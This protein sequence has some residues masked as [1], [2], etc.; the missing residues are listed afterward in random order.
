MAWPPSIADFCVLG[1]GS[2]SLAPEERQLN[3]VSPAGSLFELRGHGFVGGELVRLVPASAGSV[4][5]SGASYSTRYTV[6][7]TTDPDFFALV[8][9]AIADAGSGVLTLLRD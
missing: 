4:L 2:A 9:L 5:P 7:P 8:G 3:G 6:A 1:L